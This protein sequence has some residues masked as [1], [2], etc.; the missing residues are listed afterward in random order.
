MFGSFRISVLIRYWL[1][2]GSRI[3][4]GSSDDRDLLNTYCG[5]ENTPY[6]A[7]VKEVLAYSLGQS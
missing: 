1:W 5:S 7:I 6:F 3:A 4:I 2:F